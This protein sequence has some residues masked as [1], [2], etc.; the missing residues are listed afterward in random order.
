MCPKY[1]IKQK[2]ATIVYKYIRP[3]EALVK[4]MGPRWL[5][6]CYLAQLQSPRD[7]SC[8]PETR[9]KAV[10]ICFIY[11]IHIFIVQWLIIIFICFFTVREW[12]CPACLIRTKRRITSASSARYAQTRHHRPDH[13]YAWKDYLRLEKDYLRLGKTIYGLKK[14]YLRLEVISAE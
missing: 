12:M 11:V 14:D 4:T 9:M 5:K 3:W 1:R 2:A 6:L 8:N 13:L 10:Y 7:H